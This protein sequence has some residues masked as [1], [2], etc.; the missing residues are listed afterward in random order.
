ML[1]P[2]Q[3]KLAVKLGVA[4]LALGAA[5]YGGWAVN[6]WRLGTKIE[7]T[8]RERDAALTQGK[9]L[10]EGVRTCSSSIELAHDVATK[11][12]DAGRAMLAEAKRL[13]A[14]AQGQVKRLDELLSKPPPPDAGC[15]DAWKAIEVNRKAGGP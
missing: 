15:E 10:A 8:E 4:V 11:A 12:V 14:G 7:H 1:T 9:V 3:V 5:F 6:G 2:D 13:T